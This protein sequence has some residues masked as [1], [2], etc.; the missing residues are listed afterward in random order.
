[1]GGRDRGPLAPPWVAYMISH[2]SHHR[3]QVC[4]LAHQ[5]GFPLPVKSAYGLWVWEQVFPSMTLMNVGT[6]MH[7][8]LLGASNRALQMA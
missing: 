8:Q 1:M 7:V 6:G 3:G 2:D 4:M 5:P